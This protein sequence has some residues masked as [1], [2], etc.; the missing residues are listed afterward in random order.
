MEELKKKYD[1][2]IKKILEADEEGFLESL[3]SGLH[4]TAHVAIGKDCSPELDCTGQECT[5][6]GQMSYSEVLTCLH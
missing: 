1:E 6:Q 2:A 5:G 4:G 3:Q